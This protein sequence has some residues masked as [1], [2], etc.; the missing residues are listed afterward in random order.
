LINFAFVSVGLAVFLGSSAL[1]G[2]LSNQLLV[3]L[4]LPRRTCCVTLSLSL[5][6]MADCFGLRFTVNQSSF[7]V[8]LGF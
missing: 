4:D 3:F 2:C 7:G 1:F 6:W 8:D 5:F